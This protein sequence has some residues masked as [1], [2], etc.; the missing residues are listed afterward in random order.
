MFLYAKD[1]GKTIKEVLK[2]CNEE[3]TKSWN[4]QHPELRGD[5]DAP[6][7]AGKTNRKALIDIYNSLGIQPSV[8]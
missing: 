6:G 7:G 5:P 8:A 3:W 2:R 1:K 4:F